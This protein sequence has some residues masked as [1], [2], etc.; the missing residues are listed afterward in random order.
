M[1][2]ADTRLDPMRHHLIKELFYDLGYTSNERY[3]ALAS[4]PDF[5][6]VVSEQNVY[7]CFL[8]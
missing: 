3:K 6:Y 2:L 4:T 7:G 8:K 5:A 1:A